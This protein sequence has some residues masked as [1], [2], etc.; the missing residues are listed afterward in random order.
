MFEAGFDHD[1]SFLK[2]YEDVIDRKVTDSDERIDLIN[3]FVV[4]KQSSHLRQQRLAKNG[5]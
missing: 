2:M 1:R 5:I 4:A 3:C